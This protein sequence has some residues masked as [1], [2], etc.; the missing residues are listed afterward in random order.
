MDKK[1]LRKELDEYLDSLENTTASNNLNEPAVEYGKK[2][3]K[4]ILDELSQE[5]LLQ[6]EESIKQAR[7]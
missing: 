3:S 7:D 1:Q 5:Q 4:D 2:N 6:L